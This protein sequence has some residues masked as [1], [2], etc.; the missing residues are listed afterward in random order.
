MRPWDILA[1]NETKLSCPSL[2]LSTVYRGSLGMRMQDEPQLKA[3]I[4]DYDTNVALHRLEYR[5]RNLRMAINIEYTPDFIELRCAVTSR[6]APTQPKVVL[7]PA[8]HAHRGHSRFSP[9]YS[10]TL[11]QSFPV[12]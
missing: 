4:G 3:W 11:T 10:H 9:I 7:G 8:N 5:L 1:V 12:P 2:Y 6:S